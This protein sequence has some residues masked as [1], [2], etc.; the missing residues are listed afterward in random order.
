[1]F[2]CLVGLCSTS[3]ILLHSL[4]GLVDL[5]GKVILEASLLL[6]CFSFP[7]ICHAVTLMG[8][9]LLAG[10]KSHEVGPLLVAG[11][12]FGRALFLNLP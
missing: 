8:L 4:V 9:R 7:Q 12:S 11:S 10:I 3:F 1:M 6:L 5:V 2:H